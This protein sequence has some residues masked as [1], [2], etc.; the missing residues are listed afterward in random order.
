MK[1]PGFTAEACLDEPDGRSHWSV[2]VSALLKRSITNRVEPAQISLLGH[3]GGSIWSVPP[4]CHWTA[5]QIFVP[6]PCPPTP[7]GY[8]PPLFCGHY[9]YTGRIVLDCPPVLH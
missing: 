1:M 5:E 6:E 9:Q 7:P 3:I 2:G 4:G 8:P